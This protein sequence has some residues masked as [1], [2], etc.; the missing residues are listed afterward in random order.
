MEA[1]PK[2]VAALALLVLAAPLLAMLSDSVS[3]ADLPTYKPPSRGAPAGRIGAGTRSMVPPPQVWA[4]AP[5]HAGLTTRERPVL[6]WYL[7][8]PAATHL[9]L[10]VSGDAAGKPLLDLAIASPAS[11]GVQKLDLA[12]YGISLRP[13][14]EYRWSVT[15][16]TDP[17]QR[18]SSG[19]IQ[20]VEPS[21]AL[22]KR[23][24]GTP[25]T[26][27]AAA[28][29]EEGIWYDALAAISD[30]IE[31]SPADADLHKQRESL[32]Q[33]IGLKDAAAGDAPR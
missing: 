22:A 9:E 33:Q 17:R 10:S 8:R 26:A 4:L 27:H 24:E 14:I 25:K 20:R 23:L 3:A 16:E 21:P 11:A 31:Q 32:L 28:Y 2:R 7:P 5:D 19:R 15:A 1:V 13:G 18:P 12:R 29:A 6:Y 30:L